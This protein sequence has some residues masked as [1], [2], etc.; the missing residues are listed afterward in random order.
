VTGPV[1]ARASALA[2]LVEL[3]VFPS[4]CR[5]CREPIDEPGEKIVCHACLARLVGRSGPLCPRCGRFYDGL[6][7]DH[8]CVRCL[9]RMPVFT[10]H[11]SCGT[12]G[13]TL[14]D[15]ILL[16]KYRRY[17]PLGRP[18]ARFAHACLAADVELWAGADYLVPVPLHPARRRD[19]G[20]NQAQLLARELAGLRGIRV[21]ARALVKVRNA[22]AQAGLSA[23]ERERN[24]RGT[25][26]VRRPDRVRSR[27]LVLVDDVTTTGAT[28]REC[29]RVLT[30]AGAKEIRAITLAQA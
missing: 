6:G 4:F 25:Y 5:L 14:K 3:L 29:A 1:R 20:F 2:K 30:E 10:R 12:Y 27:T 24:V 9:E 15:V 16:F 11:R 21:L 18:L 19:R 7:A 13:G 17:A 23:A 8:L 28:I 26:I 22:P